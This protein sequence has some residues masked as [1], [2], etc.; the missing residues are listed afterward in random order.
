M[1]R[2]LQKSFGL[3]KLLSVKVAFDPIRKGPPLWNPLSSFWRAPSICVHFLHV[4]C[5]VHNL[6]KVWFPLFDYW[7]SHCRNISRKN[8]VSTYPLWSWRPCRVPFQPASSLGKG[9]GGGNHK[10]TAYLCSSLV[11]PSLLDKLQRGLNFYIS[12]LNIAMIF[13]KQHPRCLLP[14]Y[15][16]TLR[17]H[18]YFFLGK[19]FKLRK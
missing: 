7:P 4:W 13:G 2:T 15:I 16:L 9:H 10:L 11:Q 8:S 3:L 14:V 12:R 19:S 17:Y 1:P 6:P 18:S 5:N